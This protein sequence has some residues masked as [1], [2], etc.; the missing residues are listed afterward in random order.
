MKGGRREREEASG[1]E[2]NP[3]ARLYIAG[4]LGRALFVESNRGPSKMSAYV[5]DH[6]QRRAF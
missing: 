2:R 4:L 1:V 6:F 5:N 3:K